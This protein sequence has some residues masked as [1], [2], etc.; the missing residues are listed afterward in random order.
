MPTFIDARK[1]SRAFARLRDAEMSLDADLTR[2]TQT[3]G[4]APSANECNN[5]TSARQNMRRLEQ[6]KQA[7]AQLATN[8]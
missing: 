8:G 3:L 6:A 7:Y 4:H 1:W 2:L 5:D